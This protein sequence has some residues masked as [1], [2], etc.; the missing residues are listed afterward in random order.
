MQA[1]N[2]LAVVES[3]HQNDRG[4]ANG[5]KY[6]GVSEMRMNRKRETAK[7]EQSLES[8]QSVELWQENGNGS[9]DG[10]T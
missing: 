9:G 8:G 2:W 4:S 1:E 10:W 3:V 5:Q 7:V 6:I